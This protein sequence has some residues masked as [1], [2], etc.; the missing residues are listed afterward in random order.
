M[1]PMMAVAATRSGLLTFQRKSTARLRA[2]T[3]AVSQSPMAIFPS[4]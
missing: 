3:R 2:A 4:R 1:R